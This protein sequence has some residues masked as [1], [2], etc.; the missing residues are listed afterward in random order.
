MDL[1]GGAEDELGLLV[2]VGPV[3]LGNME[4][5]QHHALRV[6]ERQTGAGTQL[7]RL[8]LGYVQV[9]RDG[10]KGAVGQAHALA[11]GVVVVLAQE[12]P[13]R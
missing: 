3:Q 13:Q 7:G 6:P 5:R 11:H 12:P 8:F 10:P 2:A 4:H 9:D 1:V